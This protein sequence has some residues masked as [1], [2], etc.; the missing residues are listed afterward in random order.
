RDALD[1]I[2]AGAERNGVD[3]IFA[4][5]GDGTVHEV[6]KRLIGRPLALGIV[7]TGSGNG[8]APHL[9]LP[10]DLRPS[11]AACR[12][13]PLDTIGTASSNGVRLLGTMGV[14]FDAWVA[15]KFAAQEARGMR[16]YL[17]VGLLGLWSYPKQEYEVTVDGAA[18]R[19]VAL[20]M[21]VA[22][23]SQYGNNAWIA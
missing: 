9:G 3:V 15:N 16:T 5:G 2:V 8:L 14:G 13:R 19:Q 4:V 23:T 12:A 10:V 21:A 6:G 1:G 7:P 17:R 18:T 22:N 11:I 20:L